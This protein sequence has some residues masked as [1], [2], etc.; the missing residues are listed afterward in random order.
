MKTRVA[1]YVLGA[2]VCAAAPAF[3]FTAQ[4]PPTLCVPEDDG[5]SFGPA[6][7]SDGHAENQASG[8]STWFCPVIR[9]STNA[10]T[11]GS[12]GVNI[13]GHSLGNNTMGGWTC[14]ASSTG[15][16]I[17]CGSWHSATGSGNTSVG[18]SYGAE[19][20]S[21]SQIQD[22]FYVKMSMSSGVSI[23]GYTVLM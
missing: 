3:A 1:V 20:T 17:T 11:S 16:T 4:F 22:T 6:I 18:W 15:A 13:Y 7:D 21:G 10:F 5:V 2:M 19:W 8:A 14:R 9:N 12:P 23:F